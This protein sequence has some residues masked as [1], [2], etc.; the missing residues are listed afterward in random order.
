MLGGAERANSAAGR[1][2]WTSKA[3]S[4]SSSCS[5]ARCWARHCRG[6][7]A[8]MIICIGGQRAWAEVML[9]TFLLLLDQ[10]GR[11][12]GRGAALFS[13]CLLLPFQCSCPIFVFICSH[14]ILLPTGRWVLCRW[15]GHNLWHDIARSCRAA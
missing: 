5:L 3:G 6:K 14:Q 2:G 10:R 15:R 1:A 9:V 4:S 8:C 11:G 12:L 13:L 7:F